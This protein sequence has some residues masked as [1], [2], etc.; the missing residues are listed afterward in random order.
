MHLLTHL[1]MYLRLKQRRQL[2]WQQ[3][4]G[5]LQDSRVIFM[6]ARFD[7]RLNQR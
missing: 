2:V 7:Q 3:S 4:S 5:F 1:L 6:L